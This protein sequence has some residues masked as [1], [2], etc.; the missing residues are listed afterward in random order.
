MAKWLSSEYFRIGASRLA[1]N[2]LTEIL[3]TETKFFLILPYMDNV[4]YW[5]IATTGERLGPMTLSNSWCRSVRVPKLRYGVRDLPTGRQPAKWRAAGIFRFPPAPLCPAPPAAASSYTAPAPQR[6][7]Y[8]YQSADNQQPPI[9][10]TYLA[11]SIVAMLVYLR[12][13][14]HCSADLLPRCR[15]DIMPATMRVPA[16]ASGKTRRYGWL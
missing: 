8:N 2:L 3:G 6:M 9:P 16:K 1:N 10:P 7:P 4:Q 14:R 11:W 12:D 13:H 15:A 5:A